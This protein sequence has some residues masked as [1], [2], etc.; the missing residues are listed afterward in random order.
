MTWSVICD[1]GIFSVWICFL[2][3]F[4]PSC[5]PSWRWASPQSGSG[6]RYDHNPPLVSSLSHAA[7][8]CW[9]HTHTHTIIQKDCFYFP[10]H[11]ALT[12]PLHKYAVFITFTKNATVISSSSIQYYCYTSGLF[13]SVA[14]IS[15]CKPHTASMFTCC[16]A[17]FR[18][19]TFAQQ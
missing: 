12:F 7:A 11:P 14:F 8:S 19:C 1:Q 13:T 9:I 2:P 15:K 3:V 17:K 6:G 5:C 4:H 16:L 18:M 10:P